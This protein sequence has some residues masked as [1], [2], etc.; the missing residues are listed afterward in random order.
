MQSLDVAAKLTKQDLKAIKENAAS[1]EQYNID[2][3]E[4]IGAVRLF[5]DSQVVEAEQ[6]LRRR[7]KDSMI[8]C[9]ANGILAML[10]G[11]MTVCLLI[12]S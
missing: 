3:K 4:V 10:K 6:I 1:P 7:C 11:L 9:H 8:H 5:I 12:C 2:E